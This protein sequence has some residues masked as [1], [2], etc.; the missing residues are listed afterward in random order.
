MKSRSKAGEVKM[1]AFRCHA[2]C[3]TAVD[4]VPADTT[5]RRD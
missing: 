3:G 1:R 5:A 2:G 4:P